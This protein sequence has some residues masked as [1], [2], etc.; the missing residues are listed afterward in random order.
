MV[1]K[2]RKIAE[3]LPPRLRGIR[4]ETVIILDFE[5][6]RSLLLILFV[7]IKRVGALRGVPA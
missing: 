7:I 4:V 6:A 2:S 1:K 3:C 5:R